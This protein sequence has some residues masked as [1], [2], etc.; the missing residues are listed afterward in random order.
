[1]KIEDA[2]AIL[3]CDDAELFT[4]AGPAVLRLK[5]LEFTYLLEGGRLRDN[6]R[7]A[8]RTAVAELRLL[9]AERPCVSL[10]DFAA[11][12]KVLADSGAARPPERHARLSDAA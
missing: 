8:A 5:L 10:V 6:V 7:E 12:D 3:K 9:I 1:M 11:R 2:L 4:S